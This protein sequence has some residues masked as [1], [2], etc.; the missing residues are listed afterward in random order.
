M[1]FRITTI[2][3]ATAETIYKTWL[4]SEGHGNMTGG[5]ASITDRVGDGFKAWDGYIQGKNIELEP[6]KRILQRWRTS[7][8]RED[9]ED[10]QLEIM[11]QDIGG[12]TE[13]TLSHT[14]VPASG[15]HYIE[16]WENHYFRPMKAYFL[17]LK[18][19]V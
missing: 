18:N 5:G 4:N 12:I 11:L 16:G 17:K 15:A 3:P 2:I 13:L 7:Q 19:K 10:S 1:E 14:H 8:F 9:E 6:N